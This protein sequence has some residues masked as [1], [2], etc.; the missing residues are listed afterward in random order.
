MI[1]LQGDVGLR[2]ASRFDTST[3]GGEGNRH[4][5]PVAA[6]EGGEDLGSRSAEGRMP[7]Y[8]LG[9]RGSHHRE[10]LIG[11]PVFPKHIMDRALARSTPPV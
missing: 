4:A 5:E 1:P 10:E 2:R 3:P 7:G 9:K 6:R 8:V 11:L